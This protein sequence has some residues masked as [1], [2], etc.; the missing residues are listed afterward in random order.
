MDDIVLVQVV[1]G[2][3]NLL[4]RLG[5]I[6]FSEFPLFADTIEKL[7]AGGELGDDVELVLEEV[8]C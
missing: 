8:P 5:S 1:D 2:A 7:A 6:L 4:D 3:E